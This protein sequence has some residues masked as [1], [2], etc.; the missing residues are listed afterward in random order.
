[1]A[2]LIATVMTAPVR[3]LATFSP[4]PFTEAGSLKIRRASAA[5][6]RV[7]SA[8]EPPRAGVG[9]YPQLAQ[10]RD[11]QDAAAV[12]RR[13]DR[14]V[15]P[16]RADAGVQGAAGEQAEPAADQADQDDLD[17]QQRL[18]LAGAPPPRRA[19]PRRARG[20]AAR[21]RS[22]RRSRLL[23]TRSSGLWPQSAGRTRDRS[24]SGRLARRDGVGLARRTRMTG[25]LQ[26]EPERFDELVALALDEIPPELTAVMDNVVVL[27]EDEPPDG[28]RDLLGLYE[29]TPLTERDWA[30]GGALPDRITIFRNPTLRMCAHR[31]RG[32]RGGARD[33]RARGGAPLRHRRRPAARAGLRLSA[34]A[35]SSQPAAPRPR[36]RSAR[37]AAAPEADTR[38]S[39]SSAP[40]SE[41]RRVVASSTCRPLL[42]MNVTSPEV[43]VHVGAA[44]QVPEDLV[45]HGGRGVEVDLAGDDDG[46]DAGGRVGA[47]GEV[48]GQGHGISIDLAAAAAVAPG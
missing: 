19:P 1:M 16:Q 6:I 24:R 4:S 21:R 18:A 37:A 38:T 12:D 47:D 3:S 8:F 36:C 10:R 39:C 40:T 34:G 45:A 25:V 31:E 15:G 5:S 32:G 44:V 26:M 20:V 48:V 23:P 7:T 35:P 46:D 27:V 9:A 42:S 2:A 17:D 14:Q 22:A 41:A 30:Y 28:D 11:R 29:G 33:G 43:Q 13:L